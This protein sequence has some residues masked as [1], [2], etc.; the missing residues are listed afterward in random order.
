MSRLVHHL[1]LRP[2]LYVAAALGVVVFVAIPDVDSWVTR[3]LLGWNVGVW[4][5]LVSMGWLMLRA[6]H[7]HLKRLALAQSQGAPVVLGVVISAAVASVVAMVF[8]LATLKGLG[9]RHGLPHVLFSLS[10]VVGAWLLLPTV[11]TLNYA[12]IYYRQGT[13]CGLNFPEQSDTFKPDYL[14]FLY[15]SLTVAATSQTSDVTISSRPMRKLVLLQALLS[16]AF[17]T[18]ILAMCIN[19]AAGLF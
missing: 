1:K 18:V 10:T 14:D 12:S 11:F 5:Y 16:F 19:I 8:E 7:T 4:F 6:D 17:N 13:G 15:F 2:R 3:A 9:V